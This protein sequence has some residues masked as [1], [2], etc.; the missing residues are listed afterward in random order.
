M[1]CYMA[2]NGKCRQDGRFGKGTKTS[3]ICKENG[4]PNGGLIEMFSVHKITFISVYFEI[5]CKR[6]YRCF[7][8]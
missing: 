1:V 3:P 2:N 8:F 7:I 6:M 5:Y 4:K